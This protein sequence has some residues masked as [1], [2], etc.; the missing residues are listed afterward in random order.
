MDRIIAAMP[1]GHLHLTMQK[2]F[3]VAISRARERAELAPTM[4]GGSPI[5]SR[6]RS[7][8]GSRHWMR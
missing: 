6:K 4:R 7:A 1:S 5:G 3:Y 2:S 8:S